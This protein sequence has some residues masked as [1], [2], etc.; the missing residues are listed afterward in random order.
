VRVLHVN[1]TGLVSGAEHSL[2]DVLGGLEAQWRPTL[3]CP[4][5][6]SL[7]AAAAAREVK[8]LPIVRA[9]GSLRVDLIQTPLGFARLGLAALQ[10]S[11]HT[12]T[13]AADVVHANSIRAGLVCIAARRLTHAPT[14]VHLRDRLPRTAIADATMSF[15]ARGAS[16]IVA[17]SDYTAEGLTNVAK[18]RGAL[19]VLANPVDLKR[20]DPASSDRRKA[21]ER[22]GID[23]AELALGVIGQITP[24]KG[25]KEAIEAVSLLARDL[26]TVSLYIV[27]ETKFV[28]RH[29]R[30][31]NSAYLGELYKSVADRKLES[32]VHFLGQ[33]EDV[34]E[35]LA[36]ID[37]VLVPSWEEPFGRIVVEAMAMGRI[38][39]ATTVGG[40]ATTIE[41]GRTGLLVKPRDPALWATAV[42]RVQT[43]QPLRQRLE[44]EARLRAMDFAVAG[45]IAEL[46]G[47]Y[48]HLVRRCA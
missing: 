10:V 7:A 13:V 14:V 46:A 2:L 31:D 44:R 39:I 16:A 23:E 3:A 29:T 41:D 4:A 24:W 47:I 19:H 36:A 43:D 33:H 34:A 45:H 40:P 20:F 6:G 32:R 12:R 26:P 18:P 28:S 42:R 9:D 1:H 5:D 38:V 48:Q 22:L 8:T 35:V 25:Q 15:I 21:R 37:V 17:N 30:F 27:G 11:R